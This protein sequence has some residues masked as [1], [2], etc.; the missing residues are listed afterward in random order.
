MCGRLSPTNT[1]KTPEANRIP[2][3][4]FLVFFRRVSF[5]FRPSPEVQLAYTIRILRDFASVTLQRTRD[6]V[7]VRSLMLNLL[8]PQ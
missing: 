3:Y 4:F 1:T 8:P 5:F 6:F 2:R 7:R